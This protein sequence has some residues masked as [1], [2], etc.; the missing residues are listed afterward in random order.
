MERERRR[1]E[2]DTDWGRDRAG[3]GS[4]AGGSTAGSDRR[5]GGSGGGRDKERDRD[6]RDRDRDRDRDRGRGRDR[7]RG[8]R[9]R[10]R[11]R[12]RRYGGSRRRERSRSGSPYR[13]SG[14]GG[15][16]S[17]QHSLRRNAEPRDL[18]G[19]VPIE[20]RVRSNS[21]WDVAY[22]GFER[23][24]ADVAKQSGYFNLPGESRPVDDSVLQGMA[25][26]P[27][28]I[29]PLGVNP[30]GRPGNMTN[31]SRMNSNNPQHNVQQQQQYE[32]Q[33]QQQL[34]IEQGRAPAGRGT[35]PGTDAVFDKPLSP[36]NSRSSR[37][38]IV[39]GFKSQGFETTA[40]DVVAYFTETL[41]TIQ[42][43]HPLESL[44]SNG[45][46]S[47]RV[48]CASQLGKDGTAVVLEFATPE[49]A[50]LAYAFDG[51]YFK[52]LDNEWIMSVKR[53]QDYITPS[54]TRLEIEKEAEEGLKFRNA[55][56][57][58]DIKKAK[59][60]ADAESQEVKDKIV[61]LERFRTIKPRVVDSKNKLYVADLP[62]FLNKTQ[63]LDLL[64]AFGEV[65][66][67][68]IIVDKSGVEGESRGIVFVEYKDADDIT[69]AA[70]VGLSGMEIGGSKLRVA[71]ATYGL[72][73]PW[74]SLPMSVDAMANLAKNIEQESNSK[75]AGSSRKHQKSKKR[76]RDYDTTDEEDEEDED[77]ELE[78]GKKRGKSRVLLLLNMVTPED[79]TD[80]QEYRE[81]VEDITAECSKFGAIDQILIPR[82]DPSTVSS[83]GAGIG[84]GAMIIA[85]PT[86]NSANYGSTNAVA[87]SKPGAKTPESMGVGKVYVKFKKVGP[88]REA[89]TSLGGRKF[90][91]R[92]VISSFFPEES[93]N[94]GIF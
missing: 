27:R 11:D 6:S 85:G 9:D 32:Q 79:L 49:L 4:S 68:Q 24:P 51:S 2:R 15:G 10:E 74:A 18:S 62:Y 23:V 37:R 70:L 59:E 47:L 56:I 3:G 19:V 48:I 29:T 80:D 72:H 77:V 57:D 33:F 54:P 73:A 63:I 21:R 50:T 14:A 41:E 53:P 78:T 46:N 28:G 12:D 82:P 44:S 35:T 5:S 65:S 61:S 64:T 7:D 60:E 92:T 38:I 1:T 84:S 40:D 94:L 86:G 13:R 45:D 39:S 55:E 69:K 88:C 93:F 25:D 83:G 17:H 76:S 34:Q 66:A 30:N 52:G 42:L 31:R 91:D 26:A 89:Y 16:S 87:T 58:E 22:P 71:R 81:I 90:S 75:S 20:E 8:Y 36:E 43:V 67:L